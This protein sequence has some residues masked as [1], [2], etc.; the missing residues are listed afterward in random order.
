MMRTCFINAVNPSEQSREQAKAFHKGDWRFEG[1]Q[2][3]HPK[4]CLELPFHV[5]FMSP[6]AWWLS[7][8]S[9]FPAHLPAGD[10]LLPQVPLETQ[11]SV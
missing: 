3:N 5:T 9:R 4:R 11:H 1:R 6:V 10:C 7:L 8:L 2:E